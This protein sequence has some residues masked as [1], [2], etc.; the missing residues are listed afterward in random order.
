MFHTFSSIVEESPAIEEMKQL[1]LRFA[2]SKESILLYGESGTGKELVPQA[3]HMASPR[4]GQT[5]RD[6]ELRGAS[7][8][9]Y[10]VGAVRI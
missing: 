9:A 5:F 2:C 3:L 4:A 10:G 7:P 8:G 6:R 1:G